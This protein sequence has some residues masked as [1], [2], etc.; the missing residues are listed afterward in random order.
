MLTISRY[1]TLYCGI[2]TF[3]NYVDCSDCAAQSCGRR[4]ECA[5]HDPQA[6]LVPKPETTWIASPNYNL[7]DVFIDI[8][9]IVIHT[10]EVSLSGTLDIFENRES[11]V[12]AHFVIAPNGDIYQMVDT[13]DRAWHATYYNDRSIGI[14]M[15]GYA[16]QSSTWNENNLDSLSHL[17]AWL[18]QAYPE[19]PLTH[20]SG[21]AY[22]FV[23]DRY[24][25]TGFVGHSQVQP[26]N[27]SDPGPYFPWNRMMFEVGQIITASAIPEPSSAALLLLG[28]YASL[29]RGRKR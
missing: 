23:N 19:I 4:G 6:T 11:G 9:S 2:V 5:V 21:N 1:F 14:E 3:I 27:K 7:R 22:D 20:P 25:E 18:I 16:H 8:D 15:V 17:L 10:T 13:K 24:N 12:S 26:W 28:A 29:F